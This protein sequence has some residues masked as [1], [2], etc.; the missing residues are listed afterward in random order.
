LHSDVCKILG[1]SLH[2]GHSKGFFSVI[3]EKQPRSAATLRGIS[4]STRYRPIKSRMIAISSEI[5]ASVTIHLRKVFS[6]SAITSN[7]CESVA[8]LVE[9]EMNC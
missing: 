6:V 1:I 8:A 7:H 3:T 5:A 2:F 9:L 4:F